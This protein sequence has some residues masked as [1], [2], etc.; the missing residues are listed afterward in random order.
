MKVVGYLV[1][2]LVAVALSIV[3]GTYIRENLAKKKDAKPI[4]YL[5]QENTDLLVCSP[6]KKITSI[7][8]LPS[9]KKTIYLRFQDLKSKVCRPF[10]A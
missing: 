7:N 4:W 5:E 10:S 9:N 2:S 3:G 6:D 8:D 1:G